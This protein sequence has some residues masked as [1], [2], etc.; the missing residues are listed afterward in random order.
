VPSVAAPIA[1][2]SN[3]TDA[4]KDTGQLD[5]DATNPNTLKLPTPQLTPPS[6]LGPP[7]S[8]TIDDGVPPGFDS[9]ESGGDDSGGVFG[10]G[11]DVPA[12]FENLAGPQIQYVDIYFNERKIGATSITATPEIVTFDNPAEVAQML[13]SLKSSVPIETLLVGPFDTNGHLICYTTGDPPGCGFVEADPVAI[14]YNESD[15]RVDLF[16]APELQSV[17]SLERLRYLPVAG[18]KNTSILS[19]YTVASKLEDEDADIDFS[20]RSLLG[21]GRGNFSIEADYNSRSERKRLREFKLTHF[22]NDYEIQAGTYFTSTGGALSDV[23]LIG[24]SFATSYKSRIDLERAF[25]SE[26]VVFLQRESVVQIAIDDRIYA[27]GSYEAGNQ[28]LD[29]T[30]LPDGTYQVQIRIVDPVTGTRVETRAFTKS[31]LIPPK[32]TSVIGTSVGN[33]LEYDGDN[34]LPDVTNVSVVGFSLANRFTDQSAYKLGLLQFG[35]QSFFQTEFIYLGE[36]FSL[37]LAASAG[38]DSTVASAFRVA[39]AHKGVSINLSS[40]TFASEFNPEEGSAYQQIFTNDYKQASASI[41][42]AFSRFSVGARASY[43]REEVDQGFTESN[44]YA[45][46]YR[47]PV[48]RRKNLRGFVDANF[49]KDDVEKRLRLQF[50]LYFGRGQFNGGLN[51]AARRVDEQDWQY[52]WGLNAGWHSSNAQAWQWRAGANVRSEQGNRSAGINADVDH[53]WFAAGV[54]TNW[55]EVASGETTQ[56]SIASLG[57]HVGLDRKGLAVGGSDFAQAG[58]IIAVKGQPAGARFD[59]FV[60]NLKTASGEIGATQFIGLQPFERYSVKLVPQTTLSNGL[61]EEI[62]EFTLYPGTV[63]RISITARQEILLVGTLIDE[64]GELIANALMQTEP[65]PL[66]VDASGYVQAEL[67]PGAVV[68]VKLADGSYC[69]FVVPDAGGE[70]ILVMAEPIVCKAIPKP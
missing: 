66:I 48:L 44:Q 25:S 31:A 4:S 70:D 43:R 30:A 3:A 47:Q 18:R 69:E 29:T 24:G 37:Q 8:L 28:A 14:I 63:E 16:I 6:T 22:F 39:F 15:L 10:F 52:D 33:V 67:P 57:A 41:S 12:G 59:V 35:T 58:V 53:P 32:G 11:D 13:S 51:T 9:L 50:N 62:H 61:G 56:N 26:L 60:N 1:Q 49:Q 27:G 5:A 21:Y 40:R 45:V 55:N 68:P 19:V 65:N 54:A 7:T 38:D 17:Q 36:S 64:S 42:K 2:S 20:A 46:Y 23:D 34:A